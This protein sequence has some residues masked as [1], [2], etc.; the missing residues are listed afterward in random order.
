MSGE[1]PN[2]WLTRH[3]RIAGA[4]LVAIVFLQMAA[5]GLLEQMP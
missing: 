3:P 4:L 1:F 2:T 5:D